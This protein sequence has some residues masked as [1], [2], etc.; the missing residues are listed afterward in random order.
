M[1]TIKI[2]KDKNL[3][4]MERIQNI[5]KIRNNEKNMQEEIDTLKK[6]KEILMSN[7]RSERS[8]DN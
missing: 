6:E 7:Y 2:L 3:E 1:D 4:L 8:K 5:D